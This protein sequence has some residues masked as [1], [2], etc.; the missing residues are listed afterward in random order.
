MSSMYKIVNTFS[1]YT[2][3][4]EYFSYKCVCIH[5]IEEKYSI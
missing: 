2:R 1:Y 3:Y 4:T 5:I